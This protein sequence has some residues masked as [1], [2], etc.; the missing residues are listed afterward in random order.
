MQGYSAAARRR[1]GPSAHPRGCK[2]GAFAHSNILTS[3]STYPLET[4]WGWST[5]E[6]IILPFGNRDTVVYVALFTGPQAMVWR[7]YSLSAP[8]PR[9]GSAAA[10]ARAALSL[11]LTRR[12]QAPA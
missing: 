1:G 6:D 12:C 4:G 5:P 7:G 3:H 11:S 2:V 10:S 8:A 9:G